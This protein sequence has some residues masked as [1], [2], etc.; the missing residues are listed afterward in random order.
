MFLEEERAYA[1]EFALRAEQGIHCVLSRVSV[2][3]GRHSERRG[4]DPVMEF[5]SLAK[6]F[7]FVVKKKQLRV[8]IRCVP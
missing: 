7:T 2:G 4:Q 6:E 8:S 5:Q 1:E 3:G